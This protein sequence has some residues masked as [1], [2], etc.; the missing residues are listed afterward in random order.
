MLVML[1]VS[2]P[3]LMIILGKYPQSGGP[4]LEVFD[5]GKCNAGKTRQSVYN[6]SDTDQAKLFFELI[7]D[8]HPSYDE[9]VTALENA[10]L[11][12]KI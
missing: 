8:I 3:N 9:I 5:N 6:F 12:H 11:E 4:Y 7:R 1:R 2:Q 10:K